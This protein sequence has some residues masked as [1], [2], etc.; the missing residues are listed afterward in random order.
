MKR[1]ALLMVLMIVLSSVDSCTQ[2]AGQVNTDPAQSAAE[3]TSSS[4]VTLRMLIPYVTQDPLTDNSVKVLEEGTGYDLEIDM[5]PQS[6]GLDKLNLLFSSGDVDYDYIR[7]NGD[8]MSKSTYVTYAQKGLLKDITDLFSQYVN[9]NAIDPMG[10]DA[11]TIND[12]LYAV[13]GTGLPIP[14]GNNLVR[15]DWL[16]TLSMEPPTDMSSLY[17]MLVAFKEQDPGGL[18]TEVIPFASPASAI[19]SGIYQLFGYLYAYEERDGAIVDTRLQPEYKEYLTFMNKLYDEGLLD[20]DF[21]INTSSTITEKIAAGRVGYYTGWVDPARDFQLNM[22]SEGKDGTYF[23]GI[24]PFIAPDGVKRIATQKGLFMIGMI[25]DN[26]EKA[27]D[28]LQFIDNYLEPA[29][30]KQMIHGEEGVDYRIENGKEI[31]ITPAFDENR[32]NLFAFFPIQD[33]DAYYPLWELRT[34][35]TPEYIKIY[36]SIAAASLEYQQVSALAFAP[37]FDSI[38]ADRKIVDD[39]ATEQALKFIAGA[40]SLDEFDQFIEE[41]NT[42][43]AQ[44]ILSVMN[45]WKQGKN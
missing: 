10:I 21:P 23:Q 45:E 29:S 37:A 8:D 42:K 11:V 28:V 14:V 3:N 6:N 27:A 39:Y 25:P 41:M 16:E 35:K 31:P 44:E 32:G 2:E 17:E 5:L 4:E 1:I 20:P 36:E 40:R 7:L 15:M 24:E 30:F 18:G 9:L 22:T 34:R 12:R 13:P 38:S 19:D 33:G 43:K 26:S